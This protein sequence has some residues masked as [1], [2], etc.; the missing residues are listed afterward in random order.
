MTNLTK[1]DIDAAEEQIIQQSKRIEFY[2]TEYSIELLVNKMSNDDFFI[3]DYQREDVWEDERKRRFIESILMGLPI[4]FLFFWEEPES[5]RLEIVDGSQRLRTLEQFINDKL[6]L[7][8]LEELYSLE[9]FKFSDLPQSRQRKVK[10]RSIRGIILNEHTDA[11]ARFDL[12]DRI[13]TG[14]K[15]ANKAEVRRGALAGPFMDMVIELATNE[16]FVALSPLSEKDEN[17]RVREEL[18]SRFFAFGD[19]LKGYK[20]NVAKFVSLYTSKMNEEFEKNSSLR[21]EYENRFTITISFI[22]NNFA[23]GFRRTKN[24]KTTPR[25]RFEAIALGSYAALKN[26]SDLVGK[27]VDVESWIHGDDFKKVATSGAANV[28]SKINARV[29]FVKNRLLET[30]GV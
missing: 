26:Q 7:K 13:N 25:T 28:R 22:Q 14:S 27:K 23:W 11:Q 18:V 17:E 15:I 6:V 20:D 19:G 30:D 3:P 5:G 12:F 1:Q 2:L 9:G 16:I 4:P 29:D 21:K 24:S 10:N 8:D